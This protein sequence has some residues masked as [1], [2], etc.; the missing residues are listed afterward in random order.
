M[1]DEMEGRIYW[2]LD[3]Y[4]T[5]L[6]TV[7]IAGLILRI[8]GLGQPYFWQDEIDTVWAAKNFLEGSGFSYPVGPTEPYGRSQITS[9]L[10]IALSFSFLGYTEFAA[11]LPSVFAGIGVIAV[12]YFLGKDIGGKKLGLLS[13]SVMVFSTWAITW[14]TDARMYVH[15]Q[16]LYTLGIFLLLRW[17]SEDSFELKSKYLAGFIPVSI[18]GLHNHITYVALLVSLA[19]FL[20]IV[21]ISR[22]KNEEKFSLLNQSSYFWHILLFVSLI[23]FFMVFLKNHYVLFEYLMGYSPSWYTESTGFLY[24]LRLFH[25]NLSLYLLGL[26]FI[27][28]LKRRNTWLVPLSFGIPLF[29]HNL[30]YF[31]QPRFVFHLYPLSVLMVITPIIYIQNLLECKLDGM[32][33]QRKILWIISNFTVLLLVLVSFSNLSVVQGSLNPA[34]ELKGS[35]HRDSVKFIS[36][37]GSGEDLVI[38]TSPSMTGWYLGGINEVDYTLNLLDKRKESGEWVNSKTGVEVVRNKKSIRKIMN[39]SQGW[40]IADDQFYKEERVNRS[41]RNY[42]QKNSDKIQNKSWKNTEVY[43]FENK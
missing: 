26:G 43:R 2:P 32:L 23:G 33:S 16:F 36:E 25:E 41:V 35:N 18:L 42:V 8:N 6:L 24:Y 37:K 17:Y 5:S 7:L 40:V 3:I 39:N 29:A 15:N 20:P 4:Q 19:V 12:T 22:I 28:M 30:L 31:K 11:R 1:N 14:H 9:I 21:Y 13:S 38:S 34:E 10:P 27:L